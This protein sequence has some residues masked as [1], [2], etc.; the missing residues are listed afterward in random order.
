MDIQ[1]E[2]K[3]KGWIWWNVGDNWFAKNLVGKQVKAGT[4]RALLT[5]LEWEN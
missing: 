5:K 3:L 4:F 2:L 1:A